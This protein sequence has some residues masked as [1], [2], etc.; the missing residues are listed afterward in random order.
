MWNER[1]MPERWY[2]LLRKRMQVEEQ[3]MR[4]IRDGDIIE[5]DDLEKLMAQADS[6]DHEMLLVIRQAIVGVIETNTSAA[7]LHTR[8]AEWRAGLSRFLPSDFA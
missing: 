6:L 7:S 1:K 2:E 5:H 4:P 3:R 8:S